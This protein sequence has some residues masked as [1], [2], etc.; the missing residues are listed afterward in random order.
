LNMET[1]V[2]C[3][4]IISEIVSNSLKYAFPNE[5]NGEILVSLKTVEDGYEL[6]IKDNGIG[7]PEELN[8]DNNKS[9]GLI[10]VN[11]LTEQLDGEITIQRNHGTEFKIRFKELK[12]KERIK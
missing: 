4:L 10:L 8:I 2:P 6:I 9:L 1:A 12:Y 3:G 11:S 5:M 7:L